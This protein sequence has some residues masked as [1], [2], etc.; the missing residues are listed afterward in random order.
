MPDYKEYQ[1][2][3]A[4]EFKAYENRVRNI[5]DNHHWGEEGRFKEIIL[6]N[7]LKRVLPKNLSI[8]TGFV[9]N[10]N[11]ITSQ[12]DIIIYDNSF[13]VLFSEGDFVIT[14]PEN[15]LGIIEV[16]SKITSNQLGE[17]I[18]KANDNADVICGNGDKAIFNGIF[19]FNCD[20]SVNKLAEKLREL[21]F[22]QLKYKS[23]YQIVSNRLFNCV[24]HIAF[25][26]CMFLKLWPVGQLTQVHCNH[27]PNPYYS[28][29]RMPDDLAIAYFVSNLQEFILRHTKGNYIEPLE[30]EME[31]FLY[32]LPEGKEAYMQEKIYL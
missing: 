25:D 22:E 4:A 32:P 10:V 21:D 8:G 24:N 15:V 16:K 9:K 31:A 30:K 14:V 18:Q 17:Y 27:V 28:L 23:D 5:I 20:V 12:I 19:S 11:S 3:V 7:Y 2:S 1:K 13:P 29:Y 6:S 26:S